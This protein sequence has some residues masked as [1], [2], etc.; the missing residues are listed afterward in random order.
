MIQNRAF[1]EGKSKQ[2]ILDRIITHKEKFRWGVTNF[3]IYT[4]AN[5][6]DNVFK[7]SNLNHGIQITI[8]S[9]TLISREKADLKLIKIVCEGIPLKENENVTG[10][11][12]VY[13]NDMLK[14]HSDSSYAEYK[15]VIGKNGFVEHILIFPNHKK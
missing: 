5:I 14:N 2:D 10:K 9:S 3:P 12:T 6:I 4:I 15:R 1:S 7:H 11:G 8:S 13:I